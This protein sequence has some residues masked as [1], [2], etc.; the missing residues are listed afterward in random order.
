MKQSW[1]NTDDFIQYEPKS[2]H[3]KIISNSYYCYCYYSLWLSAGGWI[4][5]VY[6]LYL[7]TEL[8]RVFS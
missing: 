6:Y 4:K 2:K 7:Y 1:L 5:L 3:E 8:Y